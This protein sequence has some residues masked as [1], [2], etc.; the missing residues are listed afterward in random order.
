MVN[1]KKKSEENWVLG[2]RLNTEGFHNHS[3]HHTYYSILQL[4]KF[5][6]L[7]NEWATETDLNQSTGGSHNAILNSISSEIKEDSSIKRQLKENFHRAKKIRNTA[8]YSQ[9][10][11]NKTDQQR[12]N[13]ICGQVKTL[14]HEKFRSTL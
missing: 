2:N 14:I 6:I 4:M 1:L 9:V 11:V 12:F 7:K 3:I 5:I 8:D 13:I 10:Y